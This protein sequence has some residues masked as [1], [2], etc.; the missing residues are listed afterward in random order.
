MADRAGNAR[1]ART[2]CR[3]G[4]EFRSSSPRD[5]ADASRQ[6]SWNSAPARGDEAARS[7]ATFGLY[8]RYCALQGWKRTEILSLSESDLG[9]FK[10]APL[11]NGGARFTPS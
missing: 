5:A 1:F 10:D 3:A 7:R 9:G 2:S 6:Q 11:G 8:Q 4:S